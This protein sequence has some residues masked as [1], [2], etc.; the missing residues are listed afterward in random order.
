M[1]EMTFAVR[2]GVHGSSLQAHTPDNW[3]SLVRDVMVVFIDPI[4]YDPRSK[5]QKCMGGGRQ[6]ENTTLLDG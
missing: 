3:A 4:V 2:G 5:T 1:V 6:E